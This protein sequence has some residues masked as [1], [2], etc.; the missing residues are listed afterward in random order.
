MWV[1]PRRENADIYADRQ[2]KPLWYDAYGGGMGGRAVSRT[3]ISSTGQRVGGPKVE[4]MTRVV[5]RVDPPRPAFGGGGG[6]GG[7]GLTLVHLSAQ[8]QPFL[9]QNAP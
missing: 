3:V 5:V 6:G 2:Q 8:P 9:T 1:A 7:Q 4:P